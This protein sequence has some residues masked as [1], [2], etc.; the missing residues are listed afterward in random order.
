MLPY[1][2]S[3]RSVKKN[4][5]R[6]VLK[7]IHVDVHRQSFFFPVFHF[8][9]FFFCISLFLFIYL[10]FFFFILFF[11]F[12]FFFFSF[13]ISNKI[14]VIKAYFLGKNKKKSKM[15]SSSSM[16]GKNFITRHLEVV[17]LY[18]FFFISFFFQKR[19][20]GNACEIVSS[21]FPKQC[22]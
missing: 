13:N 9:F 20:V 21:F 1:P 11:F 22:A 3:I 5:F 6:H 17:S 8:F 15:S 19:G 2:R 14:G 16:L 7:Y 18:L 12:F 4:N 10:F